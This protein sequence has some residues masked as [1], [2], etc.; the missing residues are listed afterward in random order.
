[1]KVTIFT[2]LAILFVTGCST[3]NM[4]T[5]KPAIKPIN[6]SEKITMKTKKFAFSD[7]GFYKNNSE[8][9][10]LQVYATGVAV[11]DMKFYKDDDKVC[12]GYKCSNKK[13][14]KDNFLSKYYPNDLI[15][16]IL[17]KQPILDAKNLKKTTDGFVQTIKTTEYD[18]TYKTNSNSIYF[19][20]RQNKILIKLK[21][22]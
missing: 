4:L 18:I 1:M 21:D 5:P 14:F 7:T 6:K 15:V 19:K 16:N 13:Y 8:Y 3:K 22:L 20:D 10:Q 12:V 2:I 9:I 17:T 11:A